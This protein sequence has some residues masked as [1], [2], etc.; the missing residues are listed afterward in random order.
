[1]VMLGSFTIWRAAVTAWRPIADRFYLF[2]NHSWIGWIDHEWL[3]DWLKQIDHCWV[4]DFLLGPGTVA[5]FFVAFTSL[6]AAGGLLSEDSQSIFDS[7]RDQGSDSS[8]ADHQR[9][10]KII[11]YALLVR[12]LIEGWAEEVGVFASPFTFDPW[13]LSV[14]LGGIVIGAWLVHTL[15]YPLFSKAPHFSPGESSIPSWNHLRRKCGVDIGSVVATG[16]YIFIVNPFELHP[17]TLIE[18]QTLC[19]EVAIVFIAFRAALWRGLNL[20]FFSEI[21]Q[22]IASRVPCV[23]GA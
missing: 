17:L 2:P 3:G 1:M 22:R 16:F 12:A 13:D 20:S 14:E 7:K 10:M 8:W 4:N 15:S 19:L 23:T 9:L 11:L 21:P 6:Y 5:C 18:R